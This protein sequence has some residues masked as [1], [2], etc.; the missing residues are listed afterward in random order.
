MKYFLWLSLLT[1]LAPSTSL[2]AALVVKILSKARTNNYPTNL[3]R[4]GIQMH[5]QGCDPKENPLPLRQL[6]YKECS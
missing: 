6:V 4:N 3:Y 1:L 2:L 5:L